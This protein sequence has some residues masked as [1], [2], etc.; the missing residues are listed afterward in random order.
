MDLLRPTPF[1]TTCPFDGETS[2]WSADISGDAFSADH[3]PP[4][5]HTSLGSVTCLVDLLGPPEPS[6]GDSMAEWD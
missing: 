3:L 6:R 2:Y 4:V 1:Q 5:R